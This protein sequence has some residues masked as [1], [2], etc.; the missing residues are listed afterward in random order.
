MEIEQP[1]TEYEP[2]DLSKWLVIVMALILSTGYILEGYE[3]KEE[4]RYAPHIWEGKGYI[5]DNNPV[6][7]DENCYNTPNRDKN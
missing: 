1:T 6:L 2:K 7:I 5:I 4:T 3:T